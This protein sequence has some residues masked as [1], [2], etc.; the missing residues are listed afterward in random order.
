MFKICGSFCEQTCPEISKLP[1]ARKLVFRERLERC[2]IQRLATFVKDS[3]ALDLIDKLLVL[4][5]SRRFDAK[6]SLDHLF[7]SSDPA[8]SD[9]KKLLKGHRSMFA[10]KSPF[11]TYPEKEWLPSILKGEQ[12]HLRH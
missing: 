12:R 10:L 7:F 3:A 11:C 5:P 6:Q 8:P 2:L 9:L 4:E 1:F